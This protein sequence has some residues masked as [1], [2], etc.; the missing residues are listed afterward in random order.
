MTSEEMRS[1]VVNEEFFVDF[2]TAKKDLPESAG[3]RI[4]KRAK[5]LVWHLW[6][7]TEKFQSSVDGNLSDI[8]DASVEC[9]IWQEKVRSFATGVMATKDLFDTGSPEQRLVK[10]AYSDLTREVWISESVWSE[11]DDRADKMI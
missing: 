5:H 4:Y 8:K 1:R 6:H 3:E 9:I 7:A 11:I 2:W 10:A